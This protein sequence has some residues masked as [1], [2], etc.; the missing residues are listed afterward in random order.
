MNT[1][2]V[3]IYQ[4]ANT[5]YHKF[6][7]RLNKNIAN[8][9]F[10]RFTKRKQSQLLGKL[11]RL[12][13]RLFYLQTQLKLAAAGAAFS[14][15]LQCQSKLTPKLLLAHSPEIISIIHSR[16]RYHMFIGQRSCLCRFRW[17]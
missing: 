16:P 7:G 3:Q 5:K 13:N 11:E 8:G 12:R 17:R 15:M 14:L 4:S 10:H 2:V 9:R 1:L 6:R